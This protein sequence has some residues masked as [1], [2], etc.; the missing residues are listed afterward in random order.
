MFFL[1]GFRI[2]KVGW[3]GTQS[4]YCDFVSEF[5]SGWV[6][7]LYANR[8]LIG[9]TREPRT[10]RV[11]GQLYAN[12]SPSPL[13][14]LRVP[15]DQF[16]TDYGQQIPRQPWNRFA[17]NWSTSGSS[18]IDHF[19]IVSGVNPG[20]PIDLEN[21]LAK[22]PFTVDGDYSFEPDPVIAGTWNYGV[23][24][25]DAS[26]PAGT[27]GTPLTSSVTVVL[28]PDDV[29]PAADGNRFSVAAVTGTVTVGIVW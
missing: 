18:G 24:P 28:P 23:V 12:N 14:M 10:R 26:L 19:D 13:T 21:V 15:P 1:G 9:S 8:K 2:T 17:L 11:V 16:D 27:A 29:T 4:V 3:L 20:D 25:R 5:T 7:Q 22:V 6:F